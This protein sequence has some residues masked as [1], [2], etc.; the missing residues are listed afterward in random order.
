MTRIVVYGVTG[1]LGRELVE[2]LDATRWR[3]DELVGVASPESFG[4]D[5]EFRGEEQDVL[6]RKSVV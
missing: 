5:F 3:V 1:Q 2:S 4:R 6:D